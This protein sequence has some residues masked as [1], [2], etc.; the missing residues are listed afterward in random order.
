M[1]GRSQPPLSGSGVLA[2]AAKEYGTVLVIRRNQVISAQCDYAD[3]IYFVES[4]FTLSKKI[5]RDGRQLTTAISV[6]ADVINHEAFTIG[7]V[8]STTY[9]LVDTKLIRISLTDFERLI[10][11]DPI[12]QKIFWRFVA[13]QGLLAKEWLV[14]VGR[15]V[16]T[17]KTAHFI[18]EMFWRM[19][20][21]GHTE[22]DFCKFALSQ[23][24]WAD[25]LGL[26]L[27]QQ[28][29]S[30]ADLRRQGLIDW[31]TRGFRIKDQVRLEKLAKFDANYLNAALQQ[32]SVSLQGPNA[33]QLQSDREAGLDGQD[34][35]NP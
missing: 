9:S 35:S 4:G 5:L 22:G 11:K 15:L 13:Y 29:R 19:D 23:R 26:S 21:A 16:A 18:C 33:C 1:T 28:N 24:E 10:S 31:S 2:S 32:S 25:V 7:A 3:A 30:L 6:P 12:Y 8:F 34:V 17:E 20:M 27:V 14:R